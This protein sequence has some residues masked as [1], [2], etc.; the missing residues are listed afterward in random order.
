MADLGGMSDDSTD[1]DPDED[2]VVRPE[3]LDFTADRRVERLGD[4]TYVVATAGHDA[5]T[6]PD[7]DEDDASA[8]S[9]GDDETDDDRAADAAE[10]R[11]KARRRLVEYVEDRSERHG[12]VVI[13]S[14]EGDVAG[15]EAFADD[16]PTVFGELVEWYAANVSGDT[17]PPEVLGILLLASNAA[18][19]YPAKAFEDVLATYDVS[20]DDSVRDL[21]AA[22]QKSGFR[23]PPAEK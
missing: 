13:G 12:F 9:T 4:D 8:A 23:I 10:R 22:V 7:E 17:P 21:V 11:S 3:D 18:V 6:V 1:R 2:G 19:E 20:P 14:F 15:T 5:P 16:L